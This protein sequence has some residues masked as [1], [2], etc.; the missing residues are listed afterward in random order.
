M[1][2][3]VGFFLVPVGDAAVIALDLIEISVIDH[4]GPSGV[5]HL[6]VGRTSTVQGAYDG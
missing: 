5:F 2:G 4:H 3:L 1:I 6:E